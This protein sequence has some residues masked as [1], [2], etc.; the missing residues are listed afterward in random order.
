MFFLL[1]ISIHCEGIAL[2]VLDFLNYSL[3]AKISHGEDDIVE[4]EIEDMEKKYFDFAYCG[5]KRENCLLLIAACLKKE[6]KEKSVK[7]PGGMF[8]EIG[9]KEMEINVSGLLEKGKEEWKENGWIDLDFDVEKD[10]KIYFQLAFV[11]NI[12]ESWDVAANGSSFSPEGKYCLIKNG[13]W[14]PA[15]GVFVDGQ[16]C[17]SDAVDARDISKTLSGRQVAVI[18]EGEGALLAR[19]LSLAIEEDEVNYTAQ[20]GDPFCLVEVSLEG[21]HSAGKTRIMSTA[22]ILAVEDTLGCNLS[23][24][25]DGQWLVVDTRLKTLVAMRGAG[26]LTVIVDKEERGKDL[27]KIIFAAAVVVVIVAIAAITLCCCCCKR[28]KGKKTDNSIDEV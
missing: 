5:E 15:R 2:Q 6:E 11:D 21:P 13:S 19:L 12:N 18:P 1:V 9:I 25:E 8:E 4:W 14:A 7:P 3:K 20:C 17:Y 22:E 27:K 23:F 28:K 24:E 26:C 16:D 10:K